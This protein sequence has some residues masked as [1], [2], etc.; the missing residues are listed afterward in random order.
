[1]ALSRRE[2]VDSRAAAPH[3]APAGVW[4][5]PVVDWKGLSCQALGSL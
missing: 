1:M 5:D 4:P 2:V 3:G